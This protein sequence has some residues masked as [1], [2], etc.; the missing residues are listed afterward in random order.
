MRVLITGSTGFLGSNIVK[1]INSTKHEVFKL[2]HSTPREQNDI[3]WNFKDDLPSNMPDCDIMIHCA[4]LIYFGADINIDQY[5]VNTLATL[6]LC[7]YAI[8][9]NAYLVF[10]S[11]AAVNG[12]SNEKIS[13]DTPLSPDTQYGVSKFLA[14]KIIQKMAD[15]FCIL[16]IGGI[17]GY[18]GPKHLGLNNSITNAINEK[19]EPVLKGPGNGKRNYISIDEASEW[20]VHI[21]DDFQKK[22]KKEYKDI[23]YMSGCETLSI[24]EYLQTIVDVILPG[25][26]IQQIDGNVSKDMIIE[27]DTSPAPCISFKQYLINQ[28]I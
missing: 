27:G 17:Y 23:V 25:K 13:K 26:Q 2:V 19:K 10:A 1:K 8:D 22:R 18:N 14:E 24:R 7:K 16:R 3:V 12:F 4:A 28:L 21:I 15:K 11:T 20:V 5:Q 9:N 6:E